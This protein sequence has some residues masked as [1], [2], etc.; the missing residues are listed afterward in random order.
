MET[1]CMWW[2]WFAA[3]NDSFSSDFSRCAMI[4]WVFPHSSAQLFF[5]RVG[6]WFA[7]IVGIRSARLISVSPG[8]GSPLMLLLCVCIYF[9]PFHAVLSVILFFVIFLFRRTR[10]LALHTHAHL[11]WILI[12][13]FHCTTNRTTINAWRYLSNASAHWIRRGLATRVMWHLFI[14]GVWQPSKLWFKRP[15]SVFT[16]LHFSQIWPRFMKTSCRCN[17]LILNMQLW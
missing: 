3:F 16:K 11:G 9:L 4:T 12:F 5:L 10:K 8:I 1:C 13:Y 14:T 15:I 7:L 2:C 6:Y 17:F